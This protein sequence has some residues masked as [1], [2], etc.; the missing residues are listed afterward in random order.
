MPQLDRRLYPQPLD[1][2]EPRPL[3]LAYLSRSHVCRV[4]SVG[5]AQMPKPKYPMKVQ[6]QMP[7]GRVA[8][9]WGLVI[10]ISFVI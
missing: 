3:V 9:V 5:E 8:P 7:K 6:V 2:V 1:A 4:L 10:W